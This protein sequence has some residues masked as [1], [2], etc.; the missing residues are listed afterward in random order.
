VFP[1]HPA[2]AFE[3]HI[4]R[5]PGPAVAEMQQ[6]AVPQK[7][8]KKKP[9]DWAAVRF[10]VFSASAPL[11]V[12]HGLEIKI[13]RKIKAGRLRHCRHW[14]Y[15]HIQRCGEREALYAFSP[16]RGKTSRAHR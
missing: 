5:W 4:N 2:E 14:R 9:P 12:R 1:S 11:S 16:S 8:N 3:E 15:M 6:K 13:K 7:W 10:G